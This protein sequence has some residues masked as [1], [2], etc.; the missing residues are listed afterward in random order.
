M[1]NETFK[2][3]ITKHAPQQTIRPAE[4]FWSECK[5]R[6]QQQTEASPLAPP[7]PSSR[8][9]R[10]FYSALASLASAAALIILY[11][12]LHPAPETHPAVSSF[13]FGEALAHNG[14]VVLNDEPTDATIL[15]IITNDTEEDIL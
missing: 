6:A 11:V 2:T 7:L 12:S 14:A 4:A 13:Q 10:G 3:I 5:Q 9:M 8:R 1:K 15:W